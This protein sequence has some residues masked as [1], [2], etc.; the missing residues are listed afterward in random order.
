[1]LRNQKRQSESA[2]DDESVAKQPETKTI[3]L[4][5]AVINEVAGGDE[6]V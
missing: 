5:D 4:E 2:L 3:K 6:I 1:M